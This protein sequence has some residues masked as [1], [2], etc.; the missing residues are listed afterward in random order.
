MQQEGY[1]I[2]GI[3]ICAI[4]LLFVALRKKAEWLMNI[5]L[6]G[7]MGTIG[8][9]M[10]ITFNIIFERNFDISFLNLIRNYKEWCS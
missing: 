7:I 8:I 4:V 1:M 2:V 6:R 9:Y 10:I 3:I 5:I